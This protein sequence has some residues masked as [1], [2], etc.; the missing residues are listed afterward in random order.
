MRCA[1]LLLSLFAAVAAHAA[2]FSGT[3]IFIPIV[4]RTPGANN[5][6]WRSDVILSNRS[7]TQDTTVVVIYEPLGGGESHHQSIE[8]EPR[9]TLHLNDFVGTYVPVANSFG[10][11]RFIS[12]NANASIAAHAR[13]YNTGNPAGDF[14]QVVQAMPVDTLPQTAWL[15][16]LI[17][18]RGFRTNVGVANPNA[19]PVSFSMTWFDKNGETRGSAGMITIEPYGVYLMNDIWAVVGMFPDEGLSLRIRA[20]DRVY[21]YASVIRNDTGDAY[22]LIGDG[23]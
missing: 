16:G 1:A 12:Q 9:M 18:F 5:T 11:V 23:D 21:A 20:S 14:G 3:R 22:T 13:I 2:N 17:G 7:E 4:G 15:H 8:L 6:Q 10:T 19:T